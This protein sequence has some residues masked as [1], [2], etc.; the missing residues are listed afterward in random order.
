P[1]FFLN[2]FFNA[3]DPRGTILHRMGITGP[4]QPYFFDIVEF[5]GRGD[6]VKTAKE[7]SAKTN[8]G[9][10][11]RWQVMKCASIVIEEP[12]NFTKVYRFDP[13]FQPVLQRYL[14]MTGMPAATTT[15]A[16][17]TSKPPA[18]TTRAT[19]DESPRKK[20][21]FHVQYGKRAMDSSNWDEAIK[22]FQS[23][24]AEAEAQFELSW[25]DE[26]TALS[27]AVETARENAETE[28]RER[29]EQAE[30]ESREKAEREERDRIEREQREKEERETRE[31]AEREERER[32][33]REARE[34]AER[35]VKSYYNIPL[36]APEHAVL[37]ALEKQLGERIPNVE[38]VGYDTFGFTTKEKHVLHLGLYGKGLRSLPDSI[39]NLRLL[40]RLDLDGNRLE[41]IPDSIGELQSLKTLDLRDN[42]IT[43][44]PE[45]LG[46][47][48]S[49]DRLDLDNNLLTSFPDTDGQLPSLR[50]L[51]LRGNQLIDVPQSLKNL[52]GLNLKMSR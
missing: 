45:S 51:S 43:S 15:S 32:A 27:A 17:P 11:P 35:E 2:V 1:D 6:A 5:F 39:G 19:A 23:A 3:K 41:S 9:S 16:K 30:R 38:R 50:E 37:V 18:A 40:A 12:S 20:F 49:L 7:L 31:R 14:D 13:V 21:D 25:V 4:V 28:A 44:L 42:N 22:H 36:V 52:T 29:A 24:K 10:D 46:N 34:R 26:A 33:E 48:R 8:S 47:L